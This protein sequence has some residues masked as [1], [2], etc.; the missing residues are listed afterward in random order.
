[1]AQETIESKTNWNE[2]GCAVI[3][4]VGPGLGRSLCLRFAKAGYNIVLIS[5]NINKTKT[6]ENEINRQY[7]DVNTLCLSIDTSKIEE[8]K[9][10]HQKILDESNKFGRIEVLCYNASYRINS[11]ERK[12]A[13]IG[14]SF[15]FLDLELNTFEEI[16]NVNV[17]GAFIWFQLVLPDMIKNTNK[18]SILITGATA[19]IRG[20]A[21]FAGF[22][23]SKFALRALSQSI[24]REFG[25][26]NVHITHFIID[27][28]IL[29]DENDKND[30][31]MNPNHIAD[32]YYF[33]HQQPKSTWTQ[34]LDLRP[35]VE[36]W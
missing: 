15:S 10:A 16:Y 13:G 11:D 21:N 1:M 5:R 7:K 27:G 25:P 6:V 22:A 33:I 35:N 14:K 28:R 23:S 9:L 8:C 19:S 2:N 3:V 18:T 34:E 4:G 31:W 29:Y 24:A 32:T 30:E 12:L 20:S 36:K 17:K 26:K